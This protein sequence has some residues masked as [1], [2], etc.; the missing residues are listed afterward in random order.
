[1]GCVRCRVRGGQC[2]V[3]SVWGVGCVRCSMWGGQCVECG[4]WC[5]KGS[6]VCKSHVPSFHATLILV[7]AS[8]SCSN[9]AVPMREV[10]CAEYTPH[11]WDSRTLQ[12]ILDANLCFEGKSLNGRTVAI[13][14]PLD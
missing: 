3:C 4:V 12:S 1:M 8:S 14:R 11:A 13:D 9:L 10:S 7:S 2:E 5:V 6:D